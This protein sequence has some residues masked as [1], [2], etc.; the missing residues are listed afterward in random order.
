MQNTC[1]KYDNVSYDQHVQDPIC[2]NCYIA[3]EKCVANVGKKNPKT[4]QKQTDKAKKNMSFIK[5]AKM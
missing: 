1:E 4:K 3:G 5:R 2:W